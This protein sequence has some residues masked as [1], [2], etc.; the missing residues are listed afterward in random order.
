MF[1][2][3]ITKVKVEVEVRCDGLFSLTLSNLI[4]PFKKWQI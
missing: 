2:N 3:K 1:E 4:I